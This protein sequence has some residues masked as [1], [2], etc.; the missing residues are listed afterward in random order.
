MLIQVQMFENQLRQIL[1]ARQQF[2]QFANKL[3]LVAPVA[4][5][6]SKWSLLVYLTI[7]IYT[8]HAATRSA[9]FWQIAEKNDPSCE[10]RTYAR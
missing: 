6:V 7:T 1:S 10:M 2:S 9:H 8:V 5:Y 3:A 4:L